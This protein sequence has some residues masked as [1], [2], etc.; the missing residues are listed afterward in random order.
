MKCPVRTLT[1]NWE[2]EKGAVRTRLWGRQSWKSK[3]NKISKRARLIIVTGWKW[4]NIPEIMPG[5]GY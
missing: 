5:N 2:Y 3:E 4:S 1:G